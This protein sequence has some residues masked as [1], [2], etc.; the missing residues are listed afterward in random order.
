MYNYNRLEIIKDWNI[1]KTK[2]ILIELFWHGSVGNRLI[3]DE[4][5]AAYY[6]TQDKFRN[7]NSLMNYMRLQR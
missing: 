2:V 1:T 3:S 5:I 4:V 7:Q 6:S